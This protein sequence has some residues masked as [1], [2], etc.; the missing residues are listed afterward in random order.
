MEPPLIPRAEVYEMA[1][2]APAC[3][4]T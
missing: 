2:G 3:R 1:A 4:T